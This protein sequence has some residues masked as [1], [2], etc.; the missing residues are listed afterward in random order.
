MPT[1]NRSN[2]A[3]GWIACDDGLH[4][5]QM[6]KNLSHYAWVFRKVDGGLPYSVREATPHEMA[7]AEARQHLRIGVAQIAGQEPAPQPHPEPIAW[8]VGTAICWTKEEAERDAAE[9]GQTVV[10]L[11]PMTECSCARRQC[12]GCSPRHDLTGRRLGFACYLAST[13]DTPSHRPRHGF[14]WARIKAFFVDE[15]STRAV[16]TD[17]HL[18]R[19]DARKAYLDIDLRTVIQRFVVG[20]GM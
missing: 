9:V 2:D 4:L 12:R 13:P 1:E 11:G 17:E 19:A 5:I 18:G 3:D 16:N 15:R 14:A 7:H 6:D 8:M 20:S 10:G